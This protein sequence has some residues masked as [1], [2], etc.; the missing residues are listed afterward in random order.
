LICFI[1]LL[2]ID[3]TI[4]ILKTC[5]DKGVHFKLSNSVEEV[6]LKFKII[7]RSIDDIVK[8]NESIQKFKV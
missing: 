4:N 8:F 1:R 2:F 5:L 3:L 6:T 7:D